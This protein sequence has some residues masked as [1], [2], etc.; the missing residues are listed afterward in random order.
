VRTERFRSRC[1]SFWRQRLS[2]DFECAKR[3]RPPMLV[4]GHR[5]EA[6]SRCPAIH[7]LTGVDTT[8]AWYDAESHPR[9][10]GGFSPPQTANVANFEVSLLP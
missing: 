5:S 8:I 2:A 6:G 4:A 1:P 10:P 9:G 3:I 7:L